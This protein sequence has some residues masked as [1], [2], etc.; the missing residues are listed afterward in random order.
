M[1][2]RTPTELAG[3]AGF[4]DQRGMVVAAERYCK[5][6]LHVDRHDWQ[7]AFRLRPYWL[8]KCFAIDGSCRQIPEHSAFDVAVSSADGNRNLEIS[9]TSLSAPGI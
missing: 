3:F 6:H 9:A 8:Y 2:H 5:S 1:H 7:K 4:N